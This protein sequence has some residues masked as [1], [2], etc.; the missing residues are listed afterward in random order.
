MRCLGVCGSLSGVVVFEVC[1]IS[2]R[3]TVLVVALCG[4]LYCIGLGI[5]FGVCGLGLAL[6]L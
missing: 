6:V 2:G 5:G 1:G 4:A 3:I